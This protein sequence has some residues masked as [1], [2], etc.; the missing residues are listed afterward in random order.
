MHCVSSYPTKWEDVNLRGIQTLQRAFHLPVGFSDHTQGIELALV[1]VGLGAVIIEKHITLDRN[2]EGGD[3]KA[4][5]EPD[6]FETLVSKIR[7]VESAL[8]NGVKRCMPSEENTREVS[9][10]SIVA[11]TF[12]PKG[13]FLEAS[14]LALKRPGTGISPKYLPRI[15]GRLTR[16]DI[17]KDQLIEWEQLG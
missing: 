16:V 15:I 8:G 11:K 3:H 10:K 17:E 1:A 2:M 12:L 7:R 13:K 9:R 6:E 4:S 5:L 14:V